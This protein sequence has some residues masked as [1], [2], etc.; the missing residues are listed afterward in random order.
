MDDMS[1]QI[2]LD[3]LEHF[4]VNNLFWYNT[5]ETKTLCILRNVRYDCNMRAI[6]STF[7]KYNLI[8]EKIV[9]GNKYYK[10][11]VLFMDVLKNLHTV[12]MVG[13]YFTCSTNYDAIKTFG[14]DLVSMYLLKNFK[15]IEKLILHAD[16]KPIKNSN[17][18]SITLNNLK[19]LNVNYK[20][21]INLEN[22]VQTFPNLEKLFVFTSGEQTI[23]LTDIERFIQIKC[24]KSFVSL[25][26]IIKC[27]ENKT[28][29]EQFV[30][31]IS[32]IICRMLKDALM[33]YKNIKSIRVFN[34]EE[35]I[36]N[37]PAYKFGG[38]HYPG[39]DLKSSSLYDILVYSYK[40]VCVHTAVH[41]SKEYNNITTFNS[42]CGM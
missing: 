38:Y 40:V 3:T 33:K 29:V 25:D 42:I 19:E 27:V 28:P 16:G 14:T 18:N 11:M 36:E 39:F 4:S 6:M 21:S 17:R 23:E 35:Q 9:V 13:D 26:A 2:K 1:K 34:Y 7:I 24:K 22:H 41:A 31:L 20:C 12:H 8:V 5:K 15:N 10:N 32:K 30:C 37:I